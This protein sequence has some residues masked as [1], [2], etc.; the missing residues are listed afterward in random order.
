VSGRA[1]RGELSVRSAL[2]ARAPCGSECGLRGGAVHRRRL[3]ARAANT[4]RDSAYGRAGR[5]VARWVLAA[6]ER[7]VV[8]TA[9]PAVL[10]TDGDQ[11]A[12]LAVVRS[13]GA[14][15][16]PVYVCASRRRSLAGAS[17][18]ARAEG[19]V[20]DPLAD[21]QRFSADVRAL[22]AQ[23]NIGVLIPIGDASLLA[24]LP[25]R[26]RLPNVTVPFADER[27]IRRIADK[28][29]VVEAASSAGIS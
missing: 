11:R 9:R 17:R 27:I 19:L 13:L 2:G 12:A 4:V 21:P 28:A 8:V 14:A 23:W 26:A 15:G 22:V 20:A 3:D 24:T 5:G 6:G 16:H 7:G 25:D 29:A 1:A 10:V 18:Y